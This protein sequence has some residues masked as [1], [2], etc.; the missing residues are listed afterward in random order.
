MEARR[1]TEEIIIKWG[2]ECWLGVW[3]ERCYQKSGFASWWVL[4]QKVQPSQSSW[5]GK[6]YY[7]QKYGEHQGTFQSSVSPNCKVREALI[8]GNRHVQASM[9][10]KMVKNLPAEQEAWVRSLVWE[11]LQE[12]D[13]ATHSSILAWRIP[14]TEE[15]GGPWGCKESDIRHE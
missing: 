11:D 1:L 3:M 12:E 2:Q 8:Y 4:S 6:V 13:R 7:L 15:P 10:A 9:V 5:E 14:W